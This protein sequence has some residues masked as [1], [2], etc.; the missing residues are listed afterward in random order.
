MNIEDIQQFLDNKTSKGNEYVKIVF[1]KRD[2]IFGLFIKDHNDYNE[3]KS[4]N[5]W[6]IVPRSRFDAYSEK[7]DMSHARIF[8]G[9][10]FTR[11]TILKESFEFW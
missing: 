9:S 11:L 10:E 8:H 4:K 2:S 6:R 3:L 5:F 7:N 1:K